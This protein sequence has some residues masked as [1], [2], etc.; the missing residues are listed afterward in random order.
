MTGYDITW[1]IYLWT[2][3]P[4]NP[5]VARPRGNDLPTQKDVVDD[6]VVQP[7]QVRYQVR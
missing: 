6:P 4:R 5:T 7:H 3:R 2:R 1:W